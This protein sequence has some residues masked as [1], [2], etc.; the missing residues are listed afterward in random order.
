MNKN[1][2]IDLLHLR[3]NNGVFSIEPFA[4][5]IDKIDYIKKVT[6]EAAQIVFGQVESDVEQYAKILSNPYHKDRIWTSKARSELTSIHLNNLCFYVLDSYVDV[7]DR[8]N[9]GQ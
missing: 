3:N 2:F 9:G 8:I 4:P 1:K 5:R 7:F 6:P